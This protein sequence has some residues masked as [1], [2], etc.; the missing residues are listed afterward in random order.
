MPP[1]I[2]LAHDA[3]LTGRGDVR[4]AAV[5]LDEAASSARS[6][7]RSLESSWRGVAAD[8][9]LSAFAEWDR[10]ASACLG[11]LRSLADELAAAQTLLT[12]ADDTAVTAAGA[13]LAEAAS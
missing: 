5:L 12:A 3:L 10:A 4:A 1:A 2:A 7:V 8:A 13:L 11:E 6:R 9:F